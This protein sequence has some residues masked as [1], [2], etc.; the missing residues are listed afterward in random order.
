MNEKKNTFRQHFSFFK[1]SFEYSKISNVTRKRGWLGS[2]WLNQDY[3][4]S[5]TFSFVLIHWL[6][7]I[8]LVFQIRCG[9]LKCEFSRL[10]PSQFVNTELQ[11]SWYQSLLPLRNVTCSLCGNRLKLLRICW[12]RRHGT[13][14]RSDTPAKGI[15][16]GVKITECCVKKILHKFYKLDGIFGSVERHNYII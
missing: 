13:S 9:H 1:V 10:N 4:Y 7:I 12:V 3:G 14:A 16:Y 5:H 8:L 6:Y 15:Q 11:N 2:T